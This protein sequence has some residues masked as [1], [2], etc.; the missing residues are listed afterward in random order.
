MGQCNHGLIGGNGGV[1]QSADQ[2]ASGYHLASELNIDQ[3]VENNGD[4][5]QFGADASTRREPWDNAGEANPYRN[6][7]W[8]SRISAD[9]AART[10]MSIPSEPSGAQE[11]MPRTAPRISG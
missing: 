4:C 10:S 8:R 7:Q 6:N 3:M 9:G 11:G 5:G 1:Q 2:G